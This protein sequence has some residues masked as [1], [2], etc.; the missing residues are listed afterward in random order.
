M[1]WLERKDLDGCTHNPSHLGAHEPMK[2]SINRRELRSNGDHQFWIGISLI[3]L[4]SEGFK[5]FFSLL[6]LVVKYFTLVSK[7]FLYLLFWSGMVGFI[8]LGRQQVFVA[9]LGQNSDLLKLF[10]SVLRQ[11]LLHSFLWRIN[12]SVAE[13][14]DILGNFRG[15]FLRQFGL[16]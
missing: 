9:N 7:L 1:S 11:V 2:K 5:N 8:Q 10:W 16:P 3:F 6:I 15:H 12:L 13:L 14:S 4:G